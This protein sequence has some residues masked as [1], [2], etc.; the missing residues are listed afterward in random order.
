MASVI[1]PKSFGIVFEPPQLTLVYQADGKLRKRT[2][3]IRQLTATSDP[4][5]VANAIIEA[6]PSL[7]APN[8]VSN[9]QMVRLIK[10]LVEHKAAKAANA[11]GGAAAAVK[12]TDAPAQPAGKSGAPPPYMTWRAAAI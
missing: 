12:V 10:K 1:K 3:P 5:A 6:H 8:L 11:G 7:L 9:N 4:H 2:M